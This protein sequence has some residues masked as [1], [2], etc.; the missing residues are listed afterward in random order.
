MGSQSQIQ[1]S[2]DTH[3]HT[4]TH[5]RMHTHHSHGLIAHC[6]PDTILEAEGT[7]MDK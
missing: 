1:L 4:H 2:T 5:T 3:T 7:T 6:V